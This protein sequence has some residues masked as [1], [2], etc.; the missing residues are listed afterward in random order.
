MFELI[1]LNFMYFDCNSL[2]TKLEEIEYLLN[3][4]NIGVG[5]LSE[6]FLK[7]NHDVAFKN[8]SF[9]RKDDP[10]TVRGGGVAI[11]VRNDFQYVEMKLPNLKTISSACAIKLKC[12]NGFDIV[13]AS[14]YVK[15]CVKKIDSRD[16]AV[17]MRLGEKVIV[18][19]D[20]NARNERWNCKSKN[21]RGTS[22]QN[23][24]EQQN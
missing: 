15:N 19:G 9:I 23:Y 10:N 2:M 3:D 17:L 18:A 14:I 16:L 4:L 11:V 6:T 12:R 24:I 1:D 21:L 7:Q 8:Y 13:V 22:L 20:F 5:C